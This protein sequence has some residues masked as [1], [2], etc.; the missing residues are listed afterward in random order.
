MIAMKP[1]KNYISKRA[2]TRFLIL[3][4]SLRKRAN[5]RLKFEKFKSHEE[6]LKQALKGALEDKI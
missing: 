6:L 3:R 4:T 1:A 2:I 5:A